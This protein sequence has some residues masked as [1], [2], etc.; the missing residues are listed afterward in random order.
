MS[1]DEIKSIQTGH[2]ATV[3]PD[4]PNN[5]DDPIDEPDYEDPSEDL[6]P[7]A[8]TASTTAAV[9]TP[10]TTPSGDTQE[11]KGCQSTV[12]PCT[13]SVFGL[14]SLSGIALKR[15]KRKE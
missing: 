14:A 4:D 6:T 1:L 5:G 3:T 2:E 12:F 11:K 10:A 8:T 13:L 7:E 15:K 9:P